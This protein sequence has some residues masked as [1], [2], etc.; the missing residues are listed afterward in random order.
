M[1]VVKDTRALL[2]AD[3]SLCPQVHLRAQENSRLEAES[4]DLC[5]RQKLLVVALG[6]VDHQL[7]STLREFP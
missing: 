2:D 7:L 1:E 4:L 3:H 6:D 5:Q